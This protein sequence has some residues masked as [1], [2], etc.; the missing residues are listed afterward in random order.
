MDEI[1]SGSLEPL[2]DSHCQSH[3]DRESRRP[4]ALHLVLSAVEPCFLN[5]CQS[6]GG[7]L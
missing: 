1:R 4:N 3:A 7:Q 6:F 5:A 2:H